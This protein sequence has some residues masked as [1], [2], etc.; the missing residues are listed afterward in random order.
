ME[1]TY[2]GRYVIVSNVFLGL[3]NAS[4]VI[5]SGGSVFMTNL[6]GQVFRLYNPPPAID[7]QG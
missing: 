7:P 3:T 1:L 4:G 5:L 2:E 6:S